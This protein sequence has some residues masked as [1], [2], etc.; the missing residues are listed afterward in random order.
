MAIKIKK[1]SA[2]EPELITDEAPEQDHGSLY[3]LRGESP[4]GRP[5]DNL[6]GIESVDRVVMASENFFDWA[7]R[8]RNLLIAAVVGIVLVVLGIV[9]LAAQKITNR[10][11]ESQELYAAYNAAIAPVGKDFDDEE[12]LAKGDPHFDTGE[13]RLAAVYER[14]GLV[15]KSKSGVSQLG[16]LLH[17]SAG[18][19]LGKP[20]DTAVFDNYRKQART[21][22]QIALANV[23][24]S[25]Q[26]A[27]AGDLNAALD[28]LNKLDDEDGSLKAFVLE[29]RAILIETYGEPKDALKAWEDAAEAAADTPAESSIRKRI[30]IVKLQL[31]TLGQE[32]AKSDVPNGDTD[33]QGNE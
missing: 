25:T 29:Q 18:M 14:S 20:V 3:Q 8:H 15:K 17:A 16:Q 13:A 9:W 23:A 1:T 5:S 12:L 6:P 30:N 2:K 24:L 33:N 21:P 7:A 31:G 11:V 10:D 4:L 22:L 26:K 27:Q 28:E 32:Q 19:E